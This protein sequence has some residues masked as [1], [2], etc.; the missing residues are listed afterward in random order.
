M[1]FTAIGRFQRIVDLLEQ[2]CPIPYHHI[3]QACNFKVVIQS[4]L[5]QGIGG[6]QV[7]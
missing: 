7:Q 1:D 6:K 4:A 2:L 5:H 3:Q